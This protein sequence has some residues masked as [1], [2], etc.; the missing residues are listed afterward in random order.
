ML[1]CDGDARSTVISDL[2]RRHAPPAILGTRSPRIEL[3]ASSLDEAIAQAFGEWEKQPYG[4]ELIGF[5]ITDD[6]SWQK[7]SHSVRDPEGH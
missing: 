1:D 2:F 7:F 3:K 4:D 5:C 6:Y